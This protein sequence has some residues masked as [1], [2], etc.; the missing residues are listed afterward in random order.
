MITGNEPY[1]SIYIDEVTKDSFSSEGIPIKL[2]LMS[3]Y[4]AAMINNSDYL[5]MYN[6]STFKQA[7][8]KITIAAKELAE[9]T[10]KIYN[11]ES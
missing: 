3:R 5:K 8:E 1:H 10:L 2:E 4:V 9:L 11:N 7:H 6:G